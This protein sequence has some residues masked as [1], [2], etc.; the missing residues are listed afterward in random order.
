MLSSLTRLPLVLSRSS[1]T[2]PRV[3]RSNLCVV[4]GDAL[5]DQDDIVAKVA[6]NG[7][8]IAV[9]AVALA[10]L[11]SVNLDEDAVIVGTAR[12]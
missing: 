2:K 5:V 10:Q 11:R 4:T 8:D 1:R 9:K 6:A 3:V 7:G 12:T